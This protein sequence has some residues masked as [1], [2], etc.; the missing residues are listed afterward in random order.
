MVADVDNFSYICIKQNNMQI[1]DILRLKASIDS[2]SNDKT[3][4]W[5]ELAKN[6]I[7]IER[8]LP[9]IAEDFDRQR[10]EVIEKLVERD[11]ANN[12][13]VSENTYQ[14]GENEPEAIRLLT[15]I[16]EEFMAFE[17]DF[18]PFKVKDSNR[19]DLI[20]ESIEASKMQPIIEFM[21]NDD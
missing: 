20:N 1:K 9:P 13:K 14:F 12:P 15:E 5:Y 10:Q 21:F 19:L 16:Q 4:I 7:K 17:V 8:I 2:L 18:I 11:E 6:K 3:P